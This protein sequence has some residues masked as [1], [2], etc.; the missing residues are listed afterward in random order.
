MRSLITK[1]RLGLGD[2]DLL[3]LERRMAQHV[4]DPV[5]IPAQLL[6][7]AAEVE[8]ELSA[9]ASTHDD[10][11]ARLGLVLPGEGDRALPGDRHLVDPAAVEQCAA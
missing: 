5:E 10:E 11:P 7:R 2:V 9:L 3:L 8:S 1:S 4:V 6:Q